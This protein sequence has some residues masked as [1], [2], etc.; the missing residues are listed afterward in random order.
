MKD[1]IKILLIV[2]TLAGL[3]WFF[4]FIIDPYSLC[5]DHPNPELTDHLYVCEPG[6]FTFTKGIWEQKAHEKPVWEK[7]GYTLFRTDDELLK[8]KKVMISKK[9][10][11]AFWE[12]KNPQTYQLKEVELSK[13]KKI[14]KYNP[15]KLIDNV[16]IENSVEEL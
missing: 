16:S 3:G 2:A 5:K 4:K 8:A 14:C 10:V 13:L 15:N 1:F 7:K 6:G 9:D 11:N 12:C